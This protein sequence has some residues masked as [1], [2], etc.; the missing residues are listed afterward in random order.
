MLVLGFADVV[1][2]VDGLHVLHT[3]DA[4]GDA[5]RVAHPSVDQP[6]RRLNVNRTLVLDRERLHECLS[7]DLET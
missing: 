6:P 2:K 4:L 5:C 7:V 1:S 3:E